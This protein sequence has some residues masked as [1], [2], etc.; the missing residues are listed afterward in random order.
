MSGITLI[1]LSRTMAPVTEIRKSVAKVFDHC[2]RYLREKN[3]HVIKMC[4]SS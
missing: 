2:N 1:E 4:E 3:G